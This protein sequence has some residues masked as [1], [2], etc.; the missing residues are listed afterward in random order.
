MAMPHLLRRSI[1]AIG[2]LGLLNASA[3][4]VEPSSVRFATFNASLNRTAA[5][6]LIEHLQ[7]RDR[8]QIKRVAE[9]VQR[10]RPQVLLRNEF[11]YDPQGRAAELFQRNYLGVSQNGQP[12]IDYP[13]RFTAPVNTGEPSGLDLDHDGQS[14]GP[15]DAY[16]F[17][18]F[19]GQY[20]MIVY[21]MLPIDLDAV[22]TF[23]KFLWMDMP[24]AHVPR[25]PET[26]EAYYSP[27]AWNV[28]RLSSKS[29]WD[30]PLSVDGQT[31]HLLVSHPTPPVFDGPEDRNGRRNHDEI[32]LLADYIDPA[33]GNY[34]VDDLGRRGG[35]ANESHF[36][37]AGDLNADPEDGD[38]FQH[39]A[40]QLTEHHLVDGGKF[41]ASRGAV[42]RSRQRPRENASHRGE[43]AHDTADFGR[44]GNLH[45]DYV[46]PSRTL[47][48][49]ESG[50]FWPARD[51]PGAELVRASDHRMVWI[52]VQLKP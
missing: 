27:A 13:H 37:I 1:L 14:D 20:G 38:S 11:D 3:L 2:L 48:T 4:A 40:R 49:V 33:R 17:G 41:P 36:I 51:E 29:F 21:S 24:S 19:P 32:R 42:E 45:V 22:R 35:L 18:R 43:P 34:L 10:V 9:V 31:I 44:A 15:N 28:L 5:G 39:A 23:Q 25:L 7:S 26:G 30:L 46:L 6:E 8:L 52:D 47:K 12:S 16:G 50:V